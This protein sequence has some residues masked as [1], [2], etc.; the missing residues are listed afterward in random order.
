MHDTVKENEYLQKA[1]SYLNTLC[2]V[3]PNRRL[4]SLGNRAATEFFAQTVQP[5]GY[6]ID[7]TPFTC[8]DF[9]SGESS[10]TCKG[11]TFQVYVSPYSLGCDVTAE[12]V[13]VSTME[14]LEECAC[15][16]KILLMKGAL[17]V[18]QLMPK[19]FVFYNPDHHQRIYALLEAKQPTAI[20]TATGKNPD[21]VGALYP[22]PVIEDGDFDIPSVYC[23]DSVGER[24]ADATGGTLRL[25]IDARRSPA[26]GCNVIARKNPEARQKIVVCAHI[27]AYGDAPGASDDASGIVVE[28][29]LAEM[30]EEYRG[31]TG[32]EIVAFNGEDHYSAGGQMDYLRRYGPSMERIL[33]AINID[34]VGYVH[35]R[36]A[37]SFYQCPEEIHKTAETAFGGY[38]GL[39][40]GDQ[41]Y[42]GDH[43][44]FVQG[45][46]AAIAITAERMSELMASITH[47]A[48]DVPEI[49]DCRKLVEVAQ[50]LRIFITQL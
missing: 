26:T 30:L 25:K 42:Q 9:H 44:I 40:K 49:V 46:K 23:T 13:T 27:D 29:L 11:E 5:W 7:T 14:E 8:L 45:G 41:W 21:L 33:V 35:G 38:R 1:S 10:L 50:A 34:D 15:R 24:I 16:G 12:L 28:L 32:I 2:S 17:C 39:M 31:P 43:M 18:E 47:T 6:T 20:I 48:R 22:F 37:Y 36:T 3:K 4:G 19:N